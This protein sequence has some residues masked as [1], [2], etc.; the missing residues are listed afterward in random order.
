MNRE[1]IR[2]TKA[3]WY[4][5]CPVFVYSFSTFRGRALEENIKLVVGFLITL[6]EDFVIPGQRS[7]GF[8]ATFCSECH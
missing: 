7:T 5:Q 2:E 4:I 3:L 1:I 6:A 8:L